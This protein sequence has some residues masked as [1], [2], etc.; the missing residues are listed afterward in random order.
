M[1]LKRLSEALGVSG[2][3]HEVREIIKEA[4]KDQVDE[5][6][7]DTLGNLRAVKGKGKSPRVMVAAHMDEVGLM[8]SWIEKS[9]LLRF[10]KVGGIDD[11]VL[12]SK[13]VLVGKDRIPGVIGAKAI[14]L[15]DP[16][17][18]ETPL[19]YEDLYIDIG[20]KSKEEAEK[21]VKLGDFA[22]FATCY[23]EFGQRKAKGK[24]FD[25][26]VGCT[27]LMEALKG[28]YEFELNA[29]FT[30]QEEVGLRGAAVAAYDLDPQMGLVLEGTTC[31]DTPGT[32]P[33]GY[34]TEVGKGPALSLMDASSIANK[35]MVQEMVRLAQENG[36]PYQFRRTTMGGNDA[37]RI[38]LTR[39]GVPSASLSV[40][41]RYIHSPVSVISLDDL[42]NAV[43]LLGLFL[44]TVEQ[45]FRP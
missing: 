2:N 37:G 29:V 38:H 10:R 18:R 1:L 34:A 13:T 16:R 39:Q 26:R 4:I 35:K 20:A 44:K 22:A 41:C 33:E 30:V 28:Q 40:P 9:G 27:V 36:L 19:K 3:E 24:A 8:I 21:K 43:K 32:D 42:E 45:G 5:I 15:Q 12:V 11:R 23:E 7:V 31:S 6:R 14:H 17:E 25:D